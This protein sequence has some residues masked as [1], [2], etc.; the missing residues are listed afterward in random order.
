M[1]RGNAQGDLTPGLETFT[2]D[3]KVKYEGSECDVFSGCNQIE[4][5]DVLI[6]AGLIDVLI[7]FQREYFISSEQSFKCSFPCHEDG[8]DSE[9]REHRWT[10]NIKRD[11]TDYLDVVCFLLLL[12]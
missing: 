11:L 9:K 1:Y 7:V 6:Y 5:T 8:K 2:T 12:R 10:H 3:A 4:F